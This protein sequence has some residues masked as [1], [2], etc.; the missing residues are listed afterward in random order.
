MNK[1]FLKLGK[2]PL[3]NKYLKKP[4][5]LSEKKGE[6]YN[7]NICFNSKTKLVSISKIIPVNKMFNSS[8]P[9]RSS[10]SKTMINS[11]QKLSEQIKNRF[12]PKL[13]L[14]IGSNDGALIKNF[15][16]N[17]TIC[18]EPCSNLAKITRKNG[19]FTYDKYWNYSLSKKIKNKYGLVDV[20]YAANTLTHI[21]N[22]KDVFKSISNT[23]S[24]T[25]VLIFEDPSLLECIKKLHTINF[26]MS[27][28]MYFQL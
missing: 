26:I 3:A 27:I 20:I 9:Y 12:N 24:K 18:V 21:A 2:Q 16:R 6:L 19:Y 1:I 15:D 5:K 4:K 11:F 17:K 14:E 8:Y 13:F 22:L 10:M 28:Y 7:L 23:L 25:G